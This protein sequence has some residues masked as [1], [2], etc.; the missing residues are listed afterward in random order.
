VQ[1][2]PADVKKSLYSAA[3]AQRRNPAPQVKA[4]RT[5]GA[6]DWADIGTAALLSLHPFHVIDESEV[7]LEDGKAILLEWLHVLSQLEATGLDGVQLLLEGEEAITA[8]D[9]SAKLQSVRMHGQALSSPSWGECQGTGRGYSCGLWSLLHAAVQRTDDVTRTLR[10]IR[11]YLS[12]YFKCET[13]AQHFAHE[14]QA[15]EKLP[16]GK[17]WGVMWLWAVHNRVNVRTAPRFGIS[18]EGAAYPSE[19]ACP[20]CLDQ[21]GQWRED[22]V[23]QFLEGV[24][25]MGASNGTLS[26]SNSEVGKAEPEAE[27]APLLVEEGM[28]SE[29]R[30]KV[31]L[32][33]DMQLDL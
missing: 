8:E 26:P 12:V 32:Q 25:G 30:F 13:C 33:D 22:Q 24:Y 31:E 5:E 19:A 29:L 21:H 15:I 3:A 14:A 16:E 28:D 6:A 23:Y 9:W 4:P 1:A 10:S 7:I 27:Q 17:R 11:S 2:V 20:A 18:E